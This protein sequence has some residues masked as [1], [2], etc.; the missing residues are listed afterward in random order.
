MPPLKWTT[1]DRLEPIRSFEARHGAPDAGAL[2]VW[3]AWTVDSLNYLDE[4]DREYESNPPIEGQW[5]DTID[6]AHARWATATSIT[7]LDL[8]AAGLGRVF[9]QPQVGPYELDLADFDPDPSANQRTRA[10]RAG[11]RD[12]LPLSARNWIVAAFDDPRYTTIKEVR[13][14]LTHARM[15]RHLGLHRRLQLG[16]QTT[17]IGV[18]ELVE[19]ARD[20]ATDHVSSFL[21]QLPLL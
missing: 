7:A 16:F 17:Q 12:Q 15:T 8:C 4:I 18:R 1:E 2:I 14:S 20:Y 19:T 5:R 3:A 6:V 10:R 9:C 13:N 21:Q 11:R